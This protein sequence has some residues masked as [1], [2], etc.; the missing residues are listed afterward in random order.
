MVT[1]LVMS[2]HT[3]VYGRWH[4][5]GEYQRVGCSVEYSR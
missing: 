3:S 5:K 4:K 1:K 2:C